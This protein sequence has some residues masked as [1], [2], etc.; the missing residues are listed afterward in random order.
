M[1]KVIRNKKTGEVLHVFDDK[2]KVTIETDTL[3]RKVMHDHDNPPGYDKVVGGRRIRKIAGTYY[4]DHDVAENAELV[5]EVPDEN[6]PTDIKEKKYKLIK[7]TK[8][9][10]VVE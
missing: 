10:E 3:G 1:K 8:Q 4:C 2:T 6:L 5:D 9:F 7:E